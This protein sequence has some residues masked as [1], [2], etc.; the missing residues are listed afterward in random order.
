MDALHIKL[1]DEIGDY[2]I[3]GIPFS[4]S[5]ICS[6]LE[7]YDKKVHTQK[8]MKLEKMT[9]GSRRKKEFLRMV[10]IEEIVIHDFK[11]ELQ[12]PSDY[13]IKVTYKVIWGLSSNF[14]YKPEK[15]QEV[16]D[17]VPCYWFKPGREKNERIRIVEW[18]KLKLK[19]KYLSKVLGINSWVGNLGIWF[20]DYPSNEVIEFLK[21]IGYTKNKGNY[22]FKEI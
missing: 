12:R 5:G 22:F 2:L 1:I 7:S 17:Y 3:K 15:N 19:R 16:R 9:K 18:M 6:V 4:N 8:C 13:N 14:K 21:E 10:A 11:E 20:R